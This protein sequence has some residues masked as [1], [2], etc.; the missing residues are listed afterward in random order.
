LSLRDRIEKLFYKFK[1]LQRKT[2]MLSRDVNLSPQDIS[3]TSPNFINSFQKKHHGANASIYL[4][5]AIGN[6]GAGPANLSNEDK[7]PSFI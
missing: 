6:I 3:A 4:F 7:S 5:N 2:R 1:N